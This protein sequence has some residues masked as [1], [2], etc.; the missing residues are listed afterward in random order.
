MNRQTFRPA[1][2]H[3]GAVADGIC[4]LDEGMRNCSAII[5]GEE[6][7]A[8]KVAAGCS[9]VTLPAGQAAQHI[10]FVGRE[11]GAVVRFYVR[12]FSEPVYTFNRWVY[13]FPPD[14]YPR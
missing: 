9:P 1:T 3:V 4:G 2:L 12:L 13:P 10:R 11:D 7:T 14:R 5:H 8:T 6:I